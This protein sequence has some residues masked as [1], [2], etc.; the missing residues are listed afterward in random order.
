MA[1]GRQQS[2]AETSCSHTQ[3]PHPPAI[4]IFRIWGQLVILMLFQDIVGYLYCGHSSPHDQFICF[5]VRDLIHS[6]P[7]D[8]FCLPFIHAHVQACVCKVYSASRQV[9]VQTQPQ[10]ALTGSLF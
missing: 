1:Y 2:Q 10:Y 3:N 9:W 6:L 7:S 5:V 8:I 4:A